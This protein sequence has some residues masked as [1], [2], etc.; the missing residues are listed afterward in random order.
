MTTEAGLL[1]A[2]PGRSSHPSLEGLAGLGLSH[3]RLGDVGVRPFLTSGRLAR[4]RYL[5]LSDNELTDA[6][7]A[8]LTAAPFWPALRRLDLGHNRI[9]S[10]GARALLAAG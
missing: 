6:S 3:C 2:P 5:D 4:L 8:A 10:D 1:P 9:T 7:V